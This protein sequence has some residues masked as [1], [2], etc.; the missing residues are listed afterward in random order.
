MADLLKKNM[1]SKRM[2]VKSV[3]AV[4]LFGVI[5]LVF[6]FWGMWSRPGGGAGSGYAGRVGNKLISVADLK[7]ESNRLEQMYAPMLGGQVSGD[8]Q[9]Q[10][11]RGQ[12]LENLIVQEMMNQAAQKAGIYAT[13]AEI[14]D[15]IVHDIPQFQKD[16]QFQRELYF[17]LLSANHY[18]PGDFEDRI[19]KEKRTGRVRQLLEIGAQPIQIEVDKLAALHAHQ[20]D[21]NFAKFDRESIMKSMPVSETE[22]K[23]A[24]AKPD[25]MKKAQEYYDANK[26]QFNVEPQVHAEHI[27][28]KSDGS[29]DSNAKALEKITEIRAKALKGDFAKLAKENSEDVG[30][31]AKG[32]DLGY[33]KKGQMVPE[34]EA[35]AFS[36]KVGEIGQ[37]VKTQF[38]YHLIKVLDRKEGGQ[39]TFEQVKADVAKRLIAGDVYDTEVK[40][41]EESLAKNDSAAVDASLKKL[42]VKWEETG[43]FDGTVD[44]VPKLNSQEAS[45]AAF[46]VTAS[47]PLFPKLVMDAGARFILKWKAEKNETTPVKNLEQSVERE[48]TYDLMNSWIAQLRT[49]IS[50]ERNTS[51]LSGN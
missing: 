50:V 5:I 28:I 36:Q 51:V 24:L 42:G 26:Y 1:N 2:S 12:A 20:M 7:S 43:F 31:K 27:L 34:F 38:G 39:K 8:A 17:E 22:V 41:L 37:P 15:T 10:F 33:F 44:V 18:T 32:G 49:M 4:I 16:G 29:P 3:A 21:L 25:F 6:I 13:D 47:R 45:S 46:A 11:L 23:A 14:Q 30:S 48:R 19:R 9:R 35:A 40:K